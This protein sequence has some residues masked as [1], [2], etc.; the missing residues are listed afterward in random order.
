MTTMRPSAALSVLLTGF[1][2]AGC[3]QS[4]RI[5]APD[6]LARGVQGVAAD[7]PAKASRA[8]SRHKLEFVPRSDNPYFPLVPGTTFRYR[9]RTADGLETEVFTVTHEIRRIQGV[10]TIVADDVVRLGGKWIEHTLDYFASD[11]SGNVWYF[12]EDARSRDPGT[13]QVSTEGSWRAGVDSA[14]GGIIMEAHP[15]PGDAY[16]EENA[17]GV[18]QDQA[19][20]LAI[21][22]E[23]GVP[24]GEYANCLE[25]EN[26]S[27]LDPTSV[28][29]KYYAPGIGLVLEIDVP[30]GTR[31]E[32]VKRSRS[33]NEDDRDSPDD[34]GGRR[35]DHGSGGDTSDRHASRP[36]A[37]RR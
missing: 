10:S 34:D 16:S 23:A 33:G 13:G 26:F 14:E 18:A 30:D 28:E 8:G 17:P 32:L 7:R 31:N 9:S 29:H 1:A 3:S 15:Q 12:G 20:V 27:A 25:T 6:P 2:L 21:E 11:E 35:R 5:T 22:A 37:V 36:G 19:R 4:P 24:A